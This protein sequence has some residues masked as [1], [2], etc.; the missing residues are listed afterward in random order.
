M[1]PF[2]VALLTNATATGAPVQWPGGAAA[3]QVAGTFS[4][5]T[6]SLQALQP[7]GST[8]FAV[9]ASTTVIAAAFVSPL[10]LPAGAYKA[11]ITS[12][13][14]SGIYASLSAVLD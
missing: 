10:Y 14:P 2:S 12:G 3:F 5:A 7:D 11:V 1:N 13:P 8:Y 9:G 4:G 6:V